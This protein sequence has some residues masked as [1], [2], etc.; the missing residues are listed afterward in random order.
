MNSHIQ[1]LRL[2]PESKFQDIMKGKGNEPGTNSDDISKKSTTEQGIEPVTNPDIPKINTLEKSDTMPEKST[3]EEQSKEPKSVSSILE[4]IPS[5]LRTKAKSIL[6]SI[7]ENPQ[8]QMTWDDQG[9]II[10]NGNIQENTNISQLVRYVV[11]PLRNFK[12]IGA[13]EFQDQ[14]SLMGYSKRQPRKLFERL[15]PPPGKR[16][17]KRKKIQSKQSD[18]R[19]IF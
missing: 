4:T 3:P 10:I 15:A 12:P 7:R 9:R 8:S 2:I 19:T 17:R 13:N 14:L 16:Y 11:R 5:Y 1:R 18:W 6:K